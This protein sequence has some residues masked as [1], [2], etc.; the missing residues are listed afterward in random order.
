MPLKIYTYANPY[1]IN[2]EP[3]WNEIKDCVHFCVSQTMI[4]GL[5]EIYK[6]DFSKHQLLTIRNFINS[7]YKNWED[8]E[9]NVNQIMEIDNAITKL[10]IYSNN[11]E[12]SLRFNNK[13]IVKCIRLFMELGITYEEINIDT[14][15]PEQK[16]LM[17]IFRI[18][19][20][21]NKSSFLF[22]HVND[23][24]SINSAITDAFKKKYKDISFLQNINKDTIVIHGIHQFSG[25]ML[26]AIEDLSLFKNVILLFNYQEQYKSI[27]QTWDNIYSLFEAKI[28]K[29]TENQFIPMPLMID[30]YSSNV[31]A[32]S[33]GKLSNGEY[34]PLDSDI[35]QDLEIIEFE[36]LNEFAGY[37][38][39]IFEKARKIS[40]GKNTP[41]LS[42]MAEQMYSASSK[43]NDILKA[44]FPEQFGERHFLDYPIGH[45]FVAVVNMW[46][47]ENCLVKVDDFSNLRECI[48]SGIISENFN[49]ELLNTFNQI[50]T[51]IEK[52]STLVGIIN[53]L[54]ILKKLVNQN[55]TDRKRLDYCQVTKKEVHNLINALT[56]L[57]T[58]IISF[59]CDFNNNHQN[60][61][62]FYSKIQEFIS[63]R[64]QPLKELDDEMKIVLKKLLERL[65]KSNLPNTGT[66]ICLKQTMNYYL[67]QDENLFKSANWIVR[68][69]EQIEGDILR[70]YNQDANKTCYHFCCLSDKDIYSFKDEHLPYPLD[71]KFFNSCNN[72][73]WKYQIFLK[74]KLEYK[75][76]K[77]YAL[78]YGLQFNR[79]GCKLSYIKNE[80][81]TT[82]DIFNMLKLLG[83]KVTKYV[84]T[85]NGYKI[86]SLDYPVESVSNK[87]FS[88]VD[89][90]KWNTCRY[91]FALES[92]IQGGTIF[93]DRFLIHNY[94]KVLMS[95]VI[96][97][98][99]YIENITKEDVID[100]FNE[101]NSIFRIS[102]EL[103][104][105]Q[106]ISEVYKNLPNYKNIGN[107]L[108]KLQED[109]L[110]TKKL[111]YYT[112]NINFDELR[113]ENKYYYNIKPEF[114]KNCGVK[115]ICLQYHNLDD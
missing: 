31:L 97:N 51:F 56:E 111:K 38:T 50:E 102:N 77:K 33:I 100:A 44:Y 106:L 30:S 79:V 48:S 49:G 9:T 19:L 94:M 95:N 35:L 16:Y 52:E 76:F 83:I 6:K 114:C 61:K 47:N 103:E 17:E 84:N 69:F 105:T 5:E 28:S 65:E 40:K 80:N 108:M 63:N 71:I 41:V 54:K 45:F 62:K 86:P 2:K 37:V 15:T 34:Y 25:S 88:S 92:I 89:N 53:R 20:S 74:S 57:N 107:T 8:I 3:Y 72:C 90:I 112:N 59:F 98:K 99:A 18:I 104:K 32:N 109:F 67:S 43:V 60:F 96:R 14:L 82:N 87:E 27:Y 78:V 93:H 81:N 58:I 29:F 101:I 10:K 91:R 68:D 70:S 7:L 13:S 113:F 23:L 4:N 1:E 66:F 75:N 36:N 24:N 85:V 22:S 55:N 42:F 39:N 46:D 115:N 11:V 12:R 73:D 64:V 26:C 21:N 110:L